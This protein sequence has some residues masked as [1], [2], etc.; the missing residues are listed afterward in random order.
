M[1]LAAAASILAVL[2]VVAACARPATTTRGGAL[3][4]PMASAPPPVVSTAPSTAEPSSEAPRTAGP[5]VLG[6]PA[7]AASPAVDA[8]A[9]VP[10]PSDPI[11]STPIKRQSPARSSPPKVATPAPTPQ[12]PPLK[13]QMP[14]RTASPANLDF[15]SLESRL[16]ATKAIGVFT[17]LSLKN[18]IDDLL[19][20]FRLFHQGRG[21]ALPTLRDRYDLLLLKVQSLLQNDDPPLARD[22]SASREQIWRILVDPVQFVKLDSG[23]N[24]R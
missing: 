19:H 6:P 23:G 5:V 15:A 20:E 4:T 2:A 1:R 12:T 10:A 3:P 22:V 11:H 16:R 21:P 8:P 17:K 14:E 13:P 18:Q 9:E 24:P 7:D